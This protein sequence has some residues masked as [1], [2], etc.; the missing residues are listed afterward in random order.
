MG[1]VVQLTFMCCGPGD[2]SEP[3]LGV[4]SWPHE[5]LGEKECSQQRQ[6]QVQRAEREKTWGQESAVHTVE[7]FGTMGKMLAFKKKMY[8]FGSSIFVVAR[9]ACELLAVAQGI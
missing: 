9:A 4:K 2:T 6:Q 8:L 3:R 5:N 7:C 1:R